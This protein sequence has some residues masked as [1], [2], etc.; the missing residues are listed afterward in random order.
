MFFKS[1]RMYGRT[2]G[3]TDERMN[4]QTHRRINE[5]LEYGQSDEQTEKGLTDELLNLIQN[6]E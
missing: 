5:W 1:E 6:D 2:D 3:Q 4:G